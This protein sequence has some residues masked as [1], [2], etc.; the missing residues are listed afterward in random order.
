MDPPRKERPALH[1]CVARVGAAVS[2]YRSSFLSPVLATCVLR[3]SQ[4]E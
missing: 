2:G 3:E 4:N 1:I